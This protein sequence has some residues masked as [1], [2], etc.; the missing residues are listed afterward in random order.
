M[1]LSI[2]HDSIGLDDRDDVRVDK[3]LNKREEDARLAHRTAAK[4]DDFDGMH[5]RVSKIK[6]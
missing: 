2:N 1:F 4:D 6:H 3:I 5:N